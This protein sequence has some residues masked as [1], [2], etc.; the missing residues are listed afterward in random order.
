MTDFLG[1]LKADLLDRRLLPI[2]VLL[3]VVLAAALAYA[4]SGSGSSPPPGPIA[5]PVSPLSAS[6]IPVSQATLGAGQP[7]AE[8]TSGSLHRSAGAARNPFAPLPGTAPAGPTQSE[9]TPGTSKTAESST[10]S[11]STPSVNPGVGSKPEA[12][13]PTTGGGSSPTPESKPAPSKGKGKGKGNSQTVYRVAVLF[14]AV[15]AGT[16]AP[17]PNLAPYDNLKRQQPLPSVT[18][19]LL[20]FRGVIAGAKSATFT[21]VGEAILRGSAA[22]RPSASQ[23]QAIDLKLG[24]VEEL[25]YVPPEGAPVVYQLEL[26][27]ITASKSS[28]SAAR[29]KFGDQSKTGLQLLRTVGLSA[30]PG[31]RYSSAKGVLVFAGRPAFAGRASLG[32]AHAAVWGAALRG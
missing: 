21:L 4:L 12:T 13:S 32:H 8:T 6:S 25:E 31:M 5:S 29:R 18:Q 26:S 28:A 23:C 3:G 1:S 27:S 20:V 10:P 9:A 24:E 19:P 17:A 30:L 22:C 15:P 11:T 16:P 7:V 14:G 2:V